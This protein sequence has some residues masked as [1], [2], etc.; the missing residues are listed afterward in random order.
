MG[1][2]IEK[3][4]EKN[5]GGKVITLIGRACSVLI[6]VLA[7]LQLLGV[8]EDAAYV[9]MP[10]I[11]VNMLVTAVANWK[12]NRSVAIVSLFTAG[13]ILVCIAIVVFKL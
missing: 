4:K 8:W 11:C 10:L 9:Y 6:I 3:W 1:K 12:T 7:L 5:L 2:F 13:F